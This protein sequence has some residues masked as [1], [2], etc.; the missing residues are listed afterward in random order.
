M[1]STSVRSRRRGKSLQASEEVPP[2]YC[3][4]KTRIIGV[5]PGE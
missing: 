1:T 4:Y 3:E 5:Y 2:N